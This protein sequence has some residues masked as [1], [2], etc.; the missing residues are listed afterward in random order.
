M[1]GERD[2]KLNQKKLRLGSHVPP[3]ALAVLRHNDH[4]DEEATG[5]RA[6]FVCDRSDTRQST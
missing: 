2:Y 3:L 4:R 5:P 6:K 1:A